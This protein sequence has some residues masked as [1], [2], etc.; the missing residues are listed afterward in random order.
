MLILLFWLLLPKNGKSAAIMQNINKLE[1]AE[2]KVPHYYFSS[3]DIDILE[4]IN[5]KSRRQWRDSRKESVSLR[6]RYFWIKVPFEA[7]KDEELFLV[8]GWAQT[9]E[10]RAFHV[11]QGVIIDKKVDGDE[12]PITERPFKNRFP[13]FQFNLRPGLNE[14]YFLYKLDGL[15]G[16]RLT[17][18]NRDGFVENMQLG[19]TILG[20][21]FGGLGIMAIYNFLLFFAMKSKDYLFYTFYVLG[22]IGFQLSFSGFIFSHFYDHHFFTDNATIFTATF[23]LAFVVLFTLSFLQVKKYTLMATR[24]GYT[25]VAFSI[26]TAFLEIFAHQIGTFMVLIANI[27]VAF[28][29]FSLAFLLT[30]KGS[31][32]GKIYLSAWAGFAVLNAFSIFYYI[33][34]FERSILT[35]WGMVFGSILECSMISFGLA[36]KVNTLRSVNEELS[37]KSIETDI[38]LMQAKSIHESFFGTSLP[39]QIKHKLIYNPAET[40]AGDWAFIRYHEEKGR[41]YLVIADVTGHGFDSAIVSVASIGSCNAVIENFRNQKTTPE[42]ELKSIARAINQTIRLEDK[43][44]RKLMTASLIC[45]DFNIYR[46]YY[47]N[48]GHPPSFHIKPESQKVDLLF[49]RGSILGLSASI[50]INVMDFKFS[51]K[52]QFFLFTDGL[53]ENSSKINTKMIKKILS[54]MSGIDE[55]EKEFETILESVKNKKNK[56]IDDSTIL[57]VEC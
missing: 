14:I 52:D 1:G 41:L 24:I 37:Q 36:T 8:D 50:D 56:D 32:L 35:E 38:K 43:V 27:M 12:Y 47:I 29:V 25:L 23:T 40:L 49:G 10:I 2:N 15:S 3:Q 57:I 20:T 39:D 31:S 21:M 46:G 34:I 17:Y 7:K 45:L 19:Y 55:L 11:Y 48:C 13:S 33:G 28:W 5:G 18:S 51:P 44:S 26:L 30:I 22:F 16:V 54:K 6:W 9:N 42:D 4:E 53:V